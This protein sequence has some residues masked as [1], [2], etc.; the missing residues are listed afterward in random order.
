MM[1]AP[2]VLTAAVALG[3]A[4][5][6]QPSPAPNPKQPTKPSKEQP[7]TTTKQIKFYED[8]KLIDTDD[9]A[10]V[11]DSIRYVEVNGVKIEVS[12]VVAHTE[13][14]QRAIEQYSADGVMLR[15]TLQLRDPK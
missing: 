13:G 12:K 2:I 1:L 8:D 6:K 4:C 9:F 5:D 15:R 11:P 7:M 14:N 10:D 3:A